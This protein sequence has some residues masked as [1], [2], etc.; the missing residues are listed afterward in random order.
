MRVVLY[1]FCSTA[2]ILVFEF[3]CTT[4]SSTPA[5]CH[6]ELQKFHLAFYFIIVSFSTVRLNARC[7]PHYGI[8]M[9]Q[10]LR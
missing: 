1:I 2:I 4:V 9:T 5:S 6:P 8:V 3:P 10:Y 7:K